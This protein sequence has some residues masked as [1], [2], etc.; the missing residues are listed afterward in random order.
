VLYIYCADAGWHC[1]PW[2]V[3]RQR[4]KPICQIGKANVLYSLI[5]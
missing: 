3:F 5:R 4:K 2:L 1:L